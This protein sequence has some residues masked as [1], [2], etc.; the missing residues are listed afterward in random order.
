M[1]NTKMIEVKNANFFIQKNDEETVLWNFANRITM[2]GYQA[3]KINEMR[4]VIFG[5]QLQEN[6]SAL[7][8][9]LGCSPG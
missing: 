5:L 1:T 8:P 2:N 3:R 7:R 6:L 9:N 4:N